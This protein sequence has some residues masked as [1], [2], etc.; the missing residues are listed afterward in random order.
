MKAI[1][2]LLLSLQLA[3]AIN[4]SCF[5][6]KGGP[7]GTNQG[8]SFSDLPTLISSPQITA[9]MRIS[10]FLMCQNYTTKEITGFQATMR[11]LKTQNS[12]AL[13]PVGI[14]NE[15]NSTTAICKAFF[16]DTENGDYL[17]MVR[18]GFNESGVYGL[19][20]RTV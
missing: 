18:I 9:D 14:M 3:R 10:E 8:T 15:A 13:K 20:F 19:E 12:Y 6:T 2:G 17:R 16:V 7:F 4:E 1:C 5:F 11:D